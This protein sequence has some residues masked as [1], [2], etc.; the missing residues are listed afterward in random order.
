VKPP[1]NIFPQSGIL[2]DY[3]GYALPLT[4]APA[5]YHLFVGLTLVAVSLANRLWI[6]FG[7]QRLYPN[8]WTVILGP[9]SFFRKTSSIG[10]GRTILERLEEHSVLPDE[11]SPERLY[12]KLSQ[13]PTGLITWSEFGGALASFERSYMQGVKEFL[14]DLFDCRPL[15]RREL[16]GRQFE[17]KNPSISILAA[18]T[19]EWLRSRLKEDDI[20]GGFFPRFIY[21]PA[22]QKERSIAI[23]P[24]KDIRLENNIATQLNR[25]RKLEGPADLSL[26]KPFYEE[27]YGIHEAELT[28]Q[29]DGDL[30]SGFWTRLSIYL[31]K[32]ALIY[33]VAEAGDLR[34]GE[35]ALN[36]ALLLTTWLKKGIK[37]TLGKDLVFG[38][39]QRD[40]AKVLRIIEREP[41]VPHSVALKRSKMLSRYFQP[42]IDTLI[43]EG[44][45]EKKNNGYWVVKESSPSSPIFHPSIGETES[46]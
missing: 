41:G 24:E 42:V 26:I 17:I 45:V 40:K 43:A 15:Y 28:G 2:K 37:D 22:S 3:L 5:Q 8:L 21:I 12:E 13:K 6:P 31:L 33:H 36:K 14:A 32:F 44:S 4:D 11:F 23:P 25:L 27:W 39:D 46:G 10:I 35:S 16:K 29:E 1:Q 7:A 18:S 30:L 34:I 20:R 38:K 19:P 9:T